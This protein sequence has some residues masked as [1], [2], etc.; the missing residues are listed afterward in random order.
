MP[1][2]DGILLVNLGSPDAPTVPAVR[3]YLEEFLMDRYVIDVPAPLRWGIVH[4]M[5]LPFRP[6]HVAGAYASIWE[7]EGSPLILHGR[8]VAGALSAR[9]PWPVALAMRYGNPSIAA[10]LEAL[11]A[12]GARHVRVLPLYP[13]YAMA[14]VRTVVEAVAEAVRGQDPGLTW[15]VV[16]P[17]YREERYIEAL[18]RQSAPYLEGDYDHLLF[19]FHGVPERHLRKTDPTGQHCLRAEGCCDTPS[20][21]HALCYRHQVFD[22]VR[23]FVRRAGIPEGRYSVAFQSRLGRDAWLQP[24]TEARLEALA[25]SGVRRLRVMCPSFVADCLET[26]EEIGMRGRETFLEAGGEEFERI[27][28]LND[29]PAWIDTLET[30]C[31]MPH[32]EALTSAPG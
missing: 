11:A 31:R 26:I 16:P 20:A 6:R 24:A 1:E 22:T 14:T 28:C 9:L 15:E 12:A 21:A 10:G 32:V 25:A 18:V 4:G 17:F 13:H 30:Y 19:S 8:R 3:A 23:H 2:H 29:H 27:P 5:I 7:A